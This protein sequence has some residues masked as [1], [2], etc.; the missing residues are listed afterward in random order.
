LV[1]QPTGFNEPTALAREATGKSYQ[2]DPD[3][4]VEAIDGIVYTDWNNGP[5]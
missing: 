2:Q 4:L 5:R 1:A 3:G